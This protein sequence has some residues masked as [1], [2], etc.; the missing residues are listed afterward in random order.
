MEKF[1][2]IMHRAAGRH[3]GEEAVIA[4]VNEGLESYSNK[5]TDMSDDRWLAEFSKRIFQAG[6]NWQVVEN[7]WDGFEKAL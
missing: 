1:S 7:K 6:F 4:K 2:T 5:Q 3:G